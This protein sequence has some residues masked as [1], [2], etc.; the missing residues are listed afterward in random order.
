MLSLRFVYV[1]LIGLSLGLVILLF[2]K[3]LIEVADRRE[4]KKFMQERVNN[5]W[6]AEMSPLYP[7]GT[8]ESQNSVYL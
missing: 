7:A 6:N 5:K 8:E 4:R 1:I 3:C 2:L